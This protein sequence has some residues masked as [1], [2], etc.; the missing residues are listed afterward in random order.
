MP[1]SNMFMFCI[2]LPVL[3]AP[4]PMQLPANMPGKTISGWPKCLGP[5]NYLGN[6]DKTAGSG[7]AQLWALWPLGK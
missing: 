4:R 3:A 6:P 5:D 2:P 1:A 7:L